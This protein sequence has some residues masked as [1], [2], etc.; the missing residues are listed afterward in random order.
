MN[1]EFAERGDATRKDMLDFIIQ[2]ITE[3]GYSPSVREIKEGVYIGSTANVCN[4]LRV[5]KQQGKITM[6]PGQSRTIAVVGY[7][8][9]KVEK[10]GTMNE[11]LVFLKKSLDV[12]KLITDFNLHHILTNDRTAIYEN[13]DVRVSIDEMVIRVLVFKR[14]KRELTE[15]VKEYFYNN[16]MMED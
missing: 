7:E 15:C 2:F 10:A 8:Y 6:Q 4:H 9:R 14:Y 12:E 16:C 5:L 3:N 11:Y 13:K 1:K